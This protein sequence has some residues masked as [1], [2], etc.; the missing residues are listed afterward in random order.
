MRVLY[1]VLLQ[2]SMPQGK[3]LPCCTS[4]LRLE[5]TILV[6]GGDVMVDRVSRSKAG[7]R[8]VE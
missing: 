1:L 4:R 7:N 5:S 2:R 8:R 3:Q 6:V